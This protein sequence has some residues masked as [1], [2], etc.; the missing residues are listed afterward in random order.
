MLVF[1]MGGGTTDVTILKIQNQ[2]YD[3]LR[4]AGVGH[5]GGRMIDNLLFNWVL[6]NKLLPQGLV[7]DAYN[8]QAYMLWKNCLLLACKQCK[9]SS[10][11][12]LPHQKPIRPACLRGIHSVL[13]LS[14]HGRACTA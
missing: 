8:S 4:T 12:S 7:P 11:T 5:L 3:V 13:A 6:T 2:Q 14:L 9:V 1:D 10:L